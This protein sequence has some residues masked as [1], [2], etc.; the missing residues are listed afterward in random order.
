MSAAGITSDMDQNIV[1]YLNEFKVQAVVSATGSLV[2]RADALFNLS[3]KKLNPGFC[4]LHVQAAREN[5]DPR[6]FYWPWGDAD[7]DMLEL[8]QN[9]MQRL[10]LKSWSNVPTS[11]R[12]VKLKGIHVETFKN[13]E[14][15]EKLRTLYVAGHQHGTIITCGLL[16]LLKCPRL[17]N[18][19]CE[20]SIDRVLRGALWIVESYLTED[21][22]ERDIIAC[23]S[24]LIEKGYEEYAKL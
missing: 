10:A 9:N 20:T 16:R 24:E 5:G 17:T 1:R 15:L 19:N 22:S 2:E 14:R 4:D 23:Q 21:G 12:Y 11:V 13:V 8:T 7:V 3:E 18:I 6:G